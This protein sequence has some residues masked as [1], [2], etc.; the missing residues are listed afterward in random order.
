MHKTKVVKPCN[1][2][3]VLN[4]ANNLS[5]HAQPTHSQKVDSKKHEIVITN[6][7]MHN[8]QENITEDI[9]LAKGLKCSQYQKYGWIFSLSL[10]FAPIICFVWWCLEMFCDI[11]HMFLS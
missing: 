3:H 7:P 2:T 6:M 11:W 9:K 1:K 5:S 10:P 8:R 4:I